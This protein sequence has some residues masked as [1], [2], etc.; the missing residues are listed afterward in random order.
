VRT[1]NRYFEL[2][3]H[4]L[5]SDCRPPKL[6][7]ISISFLSFDSRRLQ[8]TKAAL[9]KK[10]REQLLVAAASVLSS[11][12]NRSNNSRSYKTGDAKKKGTAASSVNKKKEAS[13]TAAA[14]IGK[15]HHASLYRRQKSSAD[16]RRRNRPA[17]SSG[18]EK[19]VEI[20]ADAKKNADAD[21]GLVGSAIVFFGMFVFWFAAK[22]FLF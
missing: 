21:L 6:T 13:T 15:K 20:V 14:L 3:K 4:F 10:K 19:A 8:E 2:A 12:I 9:K 5:F 17:R 22:E 7:S 16:C 1:Y 11:S 18:T